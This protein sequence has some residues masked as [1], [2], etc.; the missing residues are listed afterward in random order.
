[1][2][3]NDKNLV[4]GD[5]P[6]N[7]LI[8]IHDPEIDPEAIMAEI[9]ARIQERRQ[10]LGY[11]K[12]Q[13]SSYGGTLLPDRPDDI[14]YD[15]ELFDHLELVNEKY[16]MVPSESDLQPSPA[17]RVPILGPLWTM[18]RE[19]AHGLV[20]FYTNRMASHQTGVNQEFVSILNGLTSLSMNQQRKIE[21]LEIELEAVRKDLEERK[22]Q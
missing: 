9:R 13:F 22:G 18:I 2:S 3:G 15:P 7:D 5:L 14:P 21:K 11:V 19:Q 6:S 1:M 4:S 16:T 8:E 20:L 10:E 17:T 12:P